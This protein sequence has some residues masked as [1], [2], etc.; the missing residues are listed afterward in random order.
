MA[1]ADIKVTLTYRIILIIICFLSTYSPPFFM[2]AI[3]P[4]DYIF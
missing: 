2:L 4:E 3:G 1:G